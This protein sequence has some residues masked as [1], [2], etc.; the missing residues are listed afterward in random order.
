MV[1]VADLI[2]HIFRVQN[3]SIDEEN[4]ARFTGVKRRTTNRIK[5]SWQSPYIV[6]IPPRKGV[7]LNEAIEDALDQLIEQADGKK[8][9][10]L[11][12]G[13]IDSTLVF[14][15]LL[16]RGLKFTVLMDENSHLEYPFLFDKI[17]N[18]DYGCDYKLFSRRGLVDLLKI[19]EDKDNLFVTGEIGDQLTGSMVTMRYP[20]EERSMLMKDVI[21]QDLFCK[22]YTIAT[23]KHQYNPI[24]IPNENGTHLAIKY[25]EDTIYEFL[26]TNESNT[27]LSEFLWALNFIFK[28]MLVMLRLH[29]VGLYF[30][31][32]NKNTFHFFNTE[33][34][35]QWAM[36]NYKENCAYVKDTDYKMPF[37]EYIYE[38]TSDPIYRDT[39]LKEPSLKISFY[40]EEEAN[41]ESDSK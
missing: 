10:L 18:G 23:E 1:E 34:F 12:S 16:S 8:L 11:W 25:C 5:D 36:W 4:L 28:Y 40:F 9:N 35:Q 22:P 3:I 29:K 32:E 39:K 17:V 20:Y 19:A 6:P 15:A 37:K 14:C 2:N 21:E 13:G 7:T 41:R 24:L 27:T 30:E 33:K 31:G 26:G 38:F